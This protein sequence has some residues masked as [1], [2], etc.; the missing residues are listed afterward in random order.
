MQ[1]RPEIDGLRAIA[2]LSVM[3]FH[4]G[5]E[6]FRGG[7]IGVD[8]FFVISGYLITTILLTEMEQGRFSLLHF[9]ERRARRILPALFLVMAATLP[10][11]WLWLFPADLVDYAQS[12]MAVAAFVSNFLFWQESGYWDAASELKPLLHSWSLAAEEQYYLLFPLLLLWIYRYGKGWIGGSLAAMIIA[13]LAFAEWTLGSDP[14]AGFYLL[15]TRLW[16]LAVGALLAQH[17]LNR[18]KTTHRIM[19]ADII[20]ATGLMMIGYAIT[21][22]DRHTPIP[23]LHALVP[24]LGTVLLIH[25]ATPGGRVGRLLAVR[26]LVAV[27]LISYS[28]YLWHFPLLALARQRSLTVLDQST[29]LALIV[30]SF[31]LAYL[32]WRYVET[33]FRARNRLSRR[34][35]FSFSLFG[36][37]LFFTI[38]LVGYLAAGWPERLPP[39]MAVENNNPRCKGIP[40]SE[41]DICTLAEGEQRLTFLIGDSHAGAIAH[42]MQAAFQQRGMGLIHIYGSGCPPIL[43]VY[44]AD[45]P[46]KRNLSCYEFNRDLF[47][48][49]ESHKEIEYIVIAARWALSMEGSR[50][51]NREGGVES[52]PVPFRPHL[53][54]V[55]NGIPQYHPDYSHQPQLAER[56]QQTI[57]HLLDLGKKV[58]LV[59]PIPEAGWNVPNYL[60]K[61]L[62]FHADGPLPPEA[63]STRHPVFTARN[64]KSYDALDRIGEHPNLFRVFPEKLF[65]NTTVTDR[66]VT[67]HTGRPLYRDDDHLS[68]FGSTL[69]VEE[70]IREIVSNW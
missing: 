3:L 44:R 28:L 42:E 11:A 22:F 30:L 13:S 40:F 6:T 24:V 49:I 43:N 15:P 36:A 48:F 1:Y 62:A 4:A 55:E 50:F 66:C 19:G 53:D 31:P 57:H 8:I 12:L 25:S 39:E 52:S 34:T 26:P 14:M 45:N 23:G 68:S 35:I 61:Y 70:I 69:L 58:V 51:D 38:G 29:M 59:Y 10:F 33:P 9:Y 67:Q 65:C 18:G 37:L 54:L 2:V 21:Q 27:G 64:R 20:A 41:G 16:E 46:K 17:L 60:S 56:Y 5:V 7:F 32:S 63:G 47:R